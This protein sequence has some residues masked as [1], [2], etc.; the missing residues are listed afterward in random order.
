MKS[1]I[2]LATAYAIGQGSAFLLLLATKE[3]FSATLAGTAYLAISLISFTIQFHDYGNSTVLAEQLRSNQT[4][5]FK[6][7]LAARGWLAAIITVL[8]CLWTKSQPTAATIEP[9]LLCLPLCAF[10][11]GRLPSSA[12]EI[13]DGYRSLAILTATIWIASTSSSALILLQPTSPTTLYSGGAFTFFLL[14]YS[15]AKKNGY[16]SERTPFRASRSAFNRILPVVIPPIS[17]QIWFRVVLVLL[18]NTLTLDKIADFGLVRYVQVAGLLGI[19]FLTRPAL[20]KYLSQRKNAGEKPHFMLLLREQKRGH[21]LAFLLSIVGAF[22]LAISLATQTTGVIAWI[23][24]LL[25]A[26]LTTLSQSATSLNQVI[27]KPSTLLA[28]DHVA[29][30]INIVVFLALVQHSPVLAFI[31]SESAHAIVILLTHAY[32]SKIE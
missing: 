6:E 31:A 30:G 13:R 3:F 4:Q 9:L 25:P 21:Q 5:G 7:S 15:F 18:A 12:V 17:G 19:S 22:G 1:S 23:P 14:I 32:L 20:T 10:I 24:L 28:L 8:F 27:A 29:L 2:Y 26:A 16:P 11:L